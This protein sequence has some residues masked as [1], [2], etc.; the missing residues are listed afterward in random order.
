M[1]PTAVAVPGEFASVYCVETTLGLL[2][3]CKQSGQ[4]LVKPLVSLCLFQSLANMTVYSSVFIF[5]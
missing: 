3:S 4:T 5:M 2:C 1:E